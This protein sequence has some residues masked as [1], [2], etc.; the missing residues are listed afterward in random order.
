MK[1]ATLLLAVN[2]LVGSAAPQPGLS[3]AYE[4]DGLDSLKS[5]RRGD[6]IIDRLRED[7]RF[8]KFVDVVEKERGLRDELEGGKQTTVFAFTDDAFKRFE[9]KWRGQDEGSRVEMRDVLRY[10]IAPES[11]ITKDCLHAGALIPTS[12]RLKTL[13]DRHQRIRIFK[14]GDHAWL[15][16]QAKIEDREVKAGNGRIYAID[17]VIMPPSNAHEML[18]AVP[19]VFSTTALGLERTGL[20]REVAKDKA[21]TVFAP[22]NAAWKTLG[23]ENLKHLFSCA[24]QKGSKMSSGG[25]SERESCRGLEDLKKILSAHIAT[26]L[27][28]STD[29]MKK[30]TMNLRTLCRDTELKVCAK[31]REGGGRSDDDSDRWADDEKHHDVRRY[32]F[33]LQNGEA[34]I[35]FT[36]GLASNAAIHMIDSVIIP[37]GVRLPHDRWM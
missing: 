22:T 29:I 33:V 1:I 9:D 19:V 10:H 14:F 32:N 37:K 5:D 35:Q 7:K 11:E 18:N 17:N 15:N 26:D 27:A 16:M 36:D 30:E 28:Y 24:G 31:R 6:S 23:L 25:G 34:R 13:D 4:N 20:C 12:L 21:L 8:S 3:L 2:A